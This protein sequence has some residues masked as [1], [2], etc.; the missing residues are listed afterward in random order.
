MTGVVVS[1]LDGAGKIMSVTF[2]RCM[3]GDDDLEIVGSVDFA[4][5]GPGALLDMGIGKYDSTF[6]GSYNFDLK[7]SKL[8]S[9]LGKW[10][11]WFTD[12]D[13]NLEELSSPPA[14]TVSSSLSS[15]CPSPL[16]ITTKVTITASRI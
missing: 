15:R 4:M 1:P 11:D 8:F 10:D 13:Q 14:P 6:W 5:V 16:L 3:L 12:P 2:V 7:V 9:I